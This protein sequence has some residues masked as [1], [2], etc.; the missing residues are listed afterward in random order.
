MISRREN[1]HQHKGTERD[2]QDAKD[3]ADDP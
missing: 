1:E 2:E 3:D